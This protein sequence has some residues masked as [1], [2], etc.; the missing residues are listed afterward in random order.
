[1]PERFDEHS[2]LSSLTVGVGVPVGIHES[3]PRTDLCLDAV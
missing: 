3:D 1:M 2:H